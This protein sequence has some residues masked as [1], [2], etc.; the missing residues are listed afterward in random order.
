MS[1]VA[2]GWPGVVPTGLRTPGAPDTVALSPGLG[3]TCCLRRGVGPAS[4]IIGGKR[5]KTQ[6]LVS[7]LTL[8]APERN[9]SAQRVCLLGCNGVPSASFLSL[10]ASPHPQTGC[11][12]GTHRACAGG[13]CSLSPFSVAKCHRLACL[14][15][16]RS[17]PPSHSVVQ[18]GWQWDCWAFWRALV[19]WSSSKD[20][21]KFCP[22][23]ISFL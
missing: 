16:P 20:K 21:T 19:L 9:L 13:V 1:A 17:S 10:W 8:R 4:S 15:H 2:R 23:C 18:A 14:R 22:S 7:S 3:G 6:V 11:L 5:I 12:H